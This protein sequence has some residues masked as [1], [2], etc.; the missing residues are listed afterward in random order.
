MPK[1]RVGRKRNRRTPLYTRENLN[2]ALE[3][4]KEMTSGKG[5][6]S[7]IARD[8]NTKFS[9]PTVLSNKVEKTKIDW[10]LLFCD[11]SFPVN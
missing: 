7:L 3:K 2:A 5:S 11:R 10:I 9:P 8:Y 4:A 6:L 1:T